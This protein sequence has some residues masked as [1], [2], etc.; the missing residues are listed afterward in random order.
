M[1][2]AVA[3]AVAPA[4]AA[5]VAPAG[6][7]PAV[8][9]VGGIISQG[10]QSSSLYV[11]ELPFDVNE[12]VLFERFNAVGPVASI[13][14]CR[15]AVTRRSLGYAYVNFQNAAD[16]ERALDTLNFELI[17]GKPCRIMWCQ[18][19]PSVR[20]SGVGN[21]FVKGLEKSID[22]KALFDAFSIFGNILSCKVVLDATANSVG[23]GFVHFET[24]QAAESAIAQA[25]GTL[26]KEKKITV[27]PFKSRKE[28]MEEYGKTEHQYK[29]VFIK[30]LPESIDETRLAQMFGEFGPIT[31]HIV[32]RGKDGDESRSKGF[33]FVCYADAASA[34]AAVDKL[35]NTEIEGQTVY[36]G[37]AMKK[38]ERAGL[39]RRNYDVH[40][41]E[42]QQ[43]SRDVNLYVKNLEED[44]DD[45]K[46]RTTFEEFGTITS[47]RVMRDEKGNS[48]G[49]GFV[50]FA[51]P[52]EATRAITEM[53]GRI[54]GRKPLYIALA[55]PKEE[56][57]QH[58]SQ[59]YRQ[60]I[61]MQRNPG[62]IAAQPYPQQIMYMPQVPAPYGRP[63]FFNP[64]ARFGGAAPRFPQQPF[65]GQPQFA[66]Q[67][68]PA[69]YGQ[70]RPPRTMMGGPQRPMPGQMPRP[71]QMPPTA[72]V[73][74]RYSNQA[75]NTPGVPQQMA[76][77]PTSNM[78]LAS[79]L[80]S[81][82]PERQKQILGDALY[83]MIAN[84][85]P[86]NAGKLTGMLLQMDNSELLH[87]L[88][89]PQSLQSEVDKANQYLEANVQAAVAAQ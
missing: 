60:R 33:A 30:N 11:G 48:R 21:V 82:D 81:A 71:G 34:K 61:Q 79:A 62:F 53:N 44:V 87:L 42:M 2:A 20:R 88:D 40:R 29:N 1:S 3:P 45:S 9:V 50:S 27:A 58:L 54:V 46:L 43:R 68:M 70:V 66:R 35:N 83:P 65:G 74:T 59:Q 22:N 37:R 72:R 80:A 63:G 52:D 77:A 78:Q 57:R 56:R 86:Q 7:A 12:G 25:N 8:P 14:V 5:P 15:D 17:N 31:S 76:Q 55:Q 89:D 38:A 41:K 16:A 19:D 39:L 4:G 67:P 51:S 49:F 85:Y 13:R 69:P 32:M 24:A 23:R 28:R 73:G 26:L 6:V 18:R 36:V 10:A 75:R 64:Q 84:V 47:S